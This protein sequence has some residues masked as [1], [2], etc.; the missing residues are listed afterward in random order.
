MSVA[1]KLINV[2]ATQGARSRPWREIMPVPPAPLV[3]VLLSAEMGFHALSHCI[4]TNQRG[5]P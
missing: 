4:H 5:L 1:S 2:K 3:S